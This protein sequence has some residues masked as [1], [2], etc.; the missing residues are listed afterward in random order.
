MKRA[1]YFLV[2]VFTEIKHG[3]NQLAVFPDALGIPEDQMQS[4]AN[5]FNLSETTF[6]LPPEDKENDFK[7]RIFT[8]MQELPMAGHPTIGTAFIM[9]RR[10]P[11]D[12]SAD[13]F[14]MRLEEKVGLIPVNLKISKG[15]PTLVT[16]TQP[17]PTFSP[18]VGSRELWAELLGLSENDISDQ[19]PSQTVSCGVPYLIIPVKTLDAVSRIDFRLDVWKRIRQDMNPGF[20]YAYTLETV[21]NHDVHGRMF[22]PETGV[23]EDAATGSANGPLGAYLVKHGLIANG[24]MT[25]MVSEQGYEMGRKSLLYLGIEKRGN[26]IT[27][28][29]VGGHC[30]IVGKGEIYLD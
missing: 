19:S 17:N 25:S 12:E 18:E 7:V 20:V 27:R 5:E 11:F 8:P 22:A 26:D 16:M 4:I 9:A 2:D 29:D 28:V 13:E 21:D 14:E 10:V 24:Q 3:G 30:V 23:L 1:N 6:V 15:I